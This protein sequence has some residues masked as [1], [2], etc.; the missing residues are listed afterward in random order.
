VGF[1]V[2]EQEARETDGKMRV[3]RKKVIQAVEL[4]GR[5]EHHHILFNIDRSRGTAP[6]A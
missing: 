3:A 1:R 6:A 5:Q 2:W 4:V